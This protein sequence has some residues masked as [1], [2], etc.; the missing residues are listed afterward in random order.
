MNALYRII[1]PGEVVIVGENMAP[2]RG[3]SLA[4]RAFVC[5][6]GPGL[7]PAQSGSA[8]IGAWQSDGQEDSIRGSW[9]SRDETVPFQLNNPDS[10]PR[11][12]TPQKPNK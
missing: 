7:S 3:S 9:I 1:N 8:I 5:S 12:V 11:L 2:S 4:G 6:S 10:K